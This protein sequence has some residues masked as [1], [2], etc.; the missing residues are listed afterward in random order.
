VPAKPR[1]KG[2]SD[3]PSKYEE[4]WN[5][6]N[7]A[8]VGHSGSKRNYPLLTYTGLKQSGKTVYA[9]DPGGEQIDG[10][11]VY[12]DF[13]SLPGQVDCAVL[14]LPKEETREWVE[15][16]ADAGIKKMWI[17]MNTDTPEAVEVAKEKGI[18]VITG[19]CAVM[20]VTPGITYHSIHKWIFQ[21]LGK[22]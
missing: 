15:K 18:D 19:T 20:Y 5:Q 21:L 16:A 1:E 10:D 17:H 11:I 4:F 9:I 22:Y 13:A 6:N 8:L 7:Y 3:M 2:E 14:E 12:P